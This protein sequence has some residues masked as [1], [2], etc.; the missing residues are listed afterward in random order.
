M[1]I[2][3]GVSVV[4]DD[5]LWVLSVVRKVHEGQKVKKV[6]A[7]LGYIIVRSKA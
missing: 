3:F 5:S 6:K 7:K 2:D 1:F 4:I